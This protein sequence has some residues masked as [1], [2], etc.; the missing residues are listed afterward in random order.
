VSG[1]Y[2][3]FGAF[4]STCPLTSGVLAGNR[5]GAAGVAP[6]SDNGGPTP[7]HA[8]EIGSAAIDGGD[9]NGCTDP[10]GNLLTADQRGGPRTVGTRCD[11][12]AFER[13]GGLTVP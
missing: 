10:V 7:T 12:G 5:T 13:Q 4:T 9:P 11:I 2:N 8:L 3:L 1:G 6:L